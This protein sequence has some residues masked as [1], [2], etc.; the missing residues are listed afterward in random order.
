MV[1]LRARFRNG[2]AGGHRRTE[3]PSRGPCCGYPGASA[4]ASAPWPLTPR[5]STRS[6]RPT[7]RRP[8]SRWRGTTR[9]LDIKWPVASDRAVL[10][11]KDRKGVDLA[12]ALDAVRTATLDSTGER[13]GESHSPTRSADRMRA[14]RSRR[15][16]V[17]RMKIAVTGGLGFIGSAVIRHLLGTAQRP[18]RRS[19]ANRFG[20]TDRTDRGHEHRQ[21]HLRRHHR[22]GG[23]PWPTRPSITTSRSTSPTGPA[24][25]DALARFEPDAVIH[26]A[27]ESHVDRSID[28]PDAFVRTNVVGTYE[29]LQAARFE[30]ERRDV[31]DSFRFLHVSTDEVFGKPRTS[32]TSRSARRPPT[33]HARP[34]LRPRRPPTT[35][36]GPGRRPTGCRPS[37]PTAPTTTARSISR[38]S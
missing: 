10:S 9:V 36:C 7:G 21:G 26:L 4:T 34:T 19:C 33:I 30:A 38:R 23:P 8:N 3:R 25:R 2:R 32:T 18:R 29:L 15:R 35:S 31:L 17:D 22:L 12:A 37:S 24:V 5:S 20:R 13:S 14:D 1:D 11:D 6:M 16:K 27:A 28:G